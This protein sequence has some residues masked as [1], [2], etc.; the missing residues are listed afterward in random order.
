MSPVADPDVLRDGANE[1]DVSD[2]GDDLTAAPSWG[3]SRTHAA[4]RGRTRWVP[5]ALYAATVFV[6]ITFNF[7]LPRLMPGDPIDALMAMGSPNFVQDDET[8]ANLAEYYNLD[9][10]LPEQY[11]NYLQ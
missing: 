9:A 10:P 3:G 1:H 8:R 6:L 5:V 7:A 4:S 2:L 11:L